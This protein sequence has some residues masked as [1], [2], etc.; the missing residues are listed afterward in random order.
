[1][2]RITRCS[3]GGLSLVPSVAV[4][5]AAGGNT[6]RMVVGTFYH[7]VGDSGKPPFPWQWMMCYYHLSSMVVWCGVLFSVGV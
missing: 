7:L 5:V 4:A 6:F 3:F 2:Y 1:M